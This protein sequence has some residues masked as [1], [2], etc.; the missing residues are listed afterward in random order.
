M[1]SV[2]S[3]LSFLIKT[4]NKY[5]LTYFLNSLLSLDVRMIRISQLSIRNTATTHNLYVK[6]NTRSGTEDEQ[7]K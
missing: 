5:S 7:R 2:R 1:R 3:L 4:P 6:S